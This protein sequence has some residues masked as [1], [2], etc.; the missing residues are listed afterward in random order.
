MQAPRKKILCIEDDAET[1]LLL[2]EEFAERVD[3][4]IETACR[5]LNVSTRIQ[6]AVKAA[7]G[8]II[9]P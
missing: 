6:A 8:G 7:S 9:E 2:A 5:K 3:F 4:H 1:A